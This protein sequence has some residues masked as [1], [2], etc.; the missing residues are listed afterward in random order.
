MIALLETVYISIQQTKETRMD[1]T[2]V[3]LKVYKVATRAVQSGTSPAVSCRHVRGRRNRYVH[4]LER[5]IRRLEL[6]RET[7]S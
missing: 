2:T 5:L 7:R 1:S 6:A 3:S 4:I